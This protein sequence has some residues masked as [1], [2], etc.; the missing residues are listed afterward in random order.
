MAN[1]RVGTNVRNPEMR[2][3][4]GGMARVFNLGA[5]ILEDTNYIVESANMKVGT[6]TIAHQPD[7][8]RNLT[9]THTEV[10]G[11]VDTLGTIVILGT[12][13]FDEI[14]SETITLVNGT[15]VVGTVAFK[16]VTS[17]T[18]VGWVIGTGNDTIIVGVGNKLAIPFP[19]AATS[20]VQLAW[21][22]GTYQAPTV[23]AGGEVGK[24]TVDLSAG[25][26]D[27]SKKARILV[28]E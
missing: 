15:K 19:I 8:P 26:Y 23:V 1:K 18:G 25:T 28:T 14:V 2:E 9:V 6:Y 5:P 22:D 17:V 21:L 24:C 12:N 10:G 7:V 11:G 20:D 16:S 3:V 4:L 27:G 13:I